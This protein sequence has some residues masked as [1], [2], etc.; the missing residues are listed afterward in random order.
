MHSLGSQ[1]SYDEDYG[2]TGVVGGRIRLRGEV[3]KN[4]LLRQRRLLRKDKESERKDLRYH[5]IGTILN[6]SLAALAMIL[7][8]TI[9]STVSILLCSFD[10]L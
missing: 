7:I 4:R 3:K 8:I 5:L 10:H 2:I 6:V 9:Y 1:G